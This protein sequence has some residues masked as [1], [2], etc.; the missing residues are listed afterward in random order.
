MVPVVKVQGVTKRY[1]NGRGIRDISFEVNRGDIYGLFGPNGA[2]KTTLLKMLAGLCT[3]DRGQVSLF[4]HSIPDQFE[5]AT[6]HASFLI[7]TMEAYSYMSAY[8]NLKLVA[9][10]YPGLPKNRIAETLEWVGL[11]AYRDEKVQRFSMGMKQRLA[12]ASALISN[13]KLVILDEP[14]NGLDIEGVVDVRNLLLRLARERSTTFLIS[15]HRIDEMERVCNRIGILHEGVLIQQGKI[16]ELL[17]DD[18]MTLEQYYL[19][20]VKK[21]KES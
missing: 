5:Q 18:T 6:E 1:P 20:Q 10:F 19:S 7:E 2:G 8:E 3:P 12:L 15:S 16:H 21:A 4:G 11:A 17:R 14:T 13:P 9:R